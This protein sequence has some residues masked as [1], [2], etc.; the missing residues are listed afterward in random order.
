MFNLLK[1]LEKSN[2]DP[3]DQVINNRLKEIEAFKKIV[4]LAQGIYKMLLDGKKKYGLESKQK[5]LTTF[6]KITFIK[7]FQFLN[8]NS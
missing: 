4:K 2:C 3:I 5:L 1:S 7:F 8:I 6:S